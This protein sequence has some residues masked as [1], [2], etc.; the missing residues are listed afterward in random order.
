MISVVKNKPETIKI[1]KFTIALT[2]Y[3]LGY[4]SCLPESIQGS[5]LKYR[6][7]YNDYSIHTENTNNRKQLIKLTFFKEQGGAA[8]I[9]VFKMNTENQIH[10]DSSSDFTKNES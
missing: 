6:D 3:L 1:T 4:K 10:I 2:T 7:R 5:I 9:I 8:A